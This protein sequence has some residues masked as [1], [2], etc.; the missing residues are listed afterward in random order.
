MLTRGGTKPIDRDAVSVENYIHTLQ[1][2]DMCFLIQLNRLV[3]V[4]FACLRVMKFEMS[5]I[6]L[7]VFR[8]KLDPD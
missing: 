6:Y 7:K 2:T 1:I 5:F 4:F 8:A 3:F